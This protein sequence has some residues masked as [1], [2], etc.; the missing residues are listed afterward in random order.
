M[1]LDILTEIGSSA[2]RLHK[3][4]VLKKH[5]DNE[6]LQAVIKATYDP[7]VNYFL[8]QIPEY[9]QIGTTDIGM[10]EA[11]DQLGHISSRLKTGHAARDHL[12][13]ILCNVNPS[14]AEVICRIIDRD[15]KAGFSESTANK[16]WP[17]LVPT[18][19]V[20]LSHKDTSGI[21]FPCYS[22]IKMDGLRVHVHKDAAGLVTAHTRNGKEVMT[23]G[24]LDM[25]GKY[26]LN[27]ETWDGELLFEKD[28]KI[29]PRTTGNGIGNKAVRGTISMEEAA[30]MVF[31]AWDIVDFTSTIPYSDRFN[32]LTKRFK[33]MFQEMANTNFRLIKSIVAE[34]LEETET[35]LQ[36]AWAH[37]E[38]GLILKNMNS[39]WEP[40]RTKNLGK[41]KAVE[42]ADLIIVALEEGKNKYEGQLGAF[43]A[44]T[45]DGLLRVNIGT[46]L[47]DTSRK[48]YFQQKY[49]GKIVT[50]KYNAIISKEG[51]DMKSLFLP[52]FVDIR[53]DKDCANS[54]KELK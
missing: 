12:Q 33:T 13:Q 42:E 2:S 43:V 1:I 5:K 7:Y 48:E 20:M 26:M 49:V 4:A 54:L 41:I 16:I 6:L 24:L 9:K 30:M 28:G 50:V 21:K 22:Q 38:E 27:G 31:T 37:G 25:A 32:E 51:S 53:F 34:T 3:E 46:G 11:L 47:T 45:S 44:E 17:G 10:E 52:V 29:L 18:F 40:K 14:S 15:L 36:D 35:M 8:K 39:V 19:D 23:H